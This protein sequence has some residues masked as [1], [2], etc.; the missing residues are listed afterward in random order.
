MWHSFASPHSHFTNVSWVHLSQYC[1]QSLSK[2]SDGI[3]SHICCLR[4]LVGDLSW[5]LMHVQHTAGAYSRC[6]LKNLQGRLEPLLVRGYESALALGW[7]QWPSN[8]R[9]I[10]LRP[11][12][13]QHCLFQCKLG[14]PP[15]SKRNNWKISEKTWKWKYSTFGERKH[16]HL[17]CH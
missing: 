9:W 15:E 6:S 7:L 3:F 8:L 12:S 11:T 13:L 2:I 10:Q 14:L 16:T 1:L 5:N 4:S 17:Y